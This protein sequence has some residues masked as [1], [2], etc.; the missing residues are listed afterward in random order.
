M[1]HSCAKWRAKAH[2]QAMPCDDVL[3]VT[4]APHALASPIV[5]PRNE[6][7]I[8]SILLVPSGSFLRHL[9]SAPKNDQPTLKPL[10]QSRPPREPPRAPAQLRPDAQDHRVVQHDWRHHHPAGPAALHGAAAQRQRHHAV[11]GRSTHRMCPLNQW[12][13]KDGMCP[14]QPP[15]LVM[16]C[17]SLYI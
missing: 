8:L 14:F 6:E 7:D 2:N 11:H 16:T 15:V 17:L 3:C 13:K 5:S 12:P 1:A 4:D 9:W 10:K